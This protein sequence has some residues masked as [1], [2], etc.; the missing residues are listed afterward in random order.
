MHFS[1][2]DEVTLKNEVP[3]DGVPG[4]LQVYKLMIFES[5]HNV[6]KGSPVLHPRALHFSCHFIPK[7][8]M[9]YIPNDTSSIMTLHPLMHFV[10][11]GTSS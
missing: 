10:P 2:R 7:G 6:V 5:F 1:L 11:N 8:K 3:W 4:N 9:H